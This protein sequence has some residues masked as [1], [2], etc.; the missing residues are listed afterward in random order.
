ML[1]LTPTAYQSGSSSHEQGISKAGNRRLRR[2]MV[3]LA[4]CWL[5][6]QPFSAL[7]QWY[8]RRFG[9]GQRARKVGIVALARKLLIALWRWLERSELPEGAVLCPWRPKVNGV[10]KA[11][12]AA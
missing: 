4:W 9:V 12:A 3:E 8:Q 5:H 7:S 6:W 1:G 11:K 2:L 10:R